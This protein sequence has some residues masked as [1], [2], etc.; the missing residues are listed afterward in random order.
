MKNLKFFSRMAV[1]VAAVSMLMVS[2]KGKEDEVA[3]PADYEGTWVNITAEGMLSA[4]TTA[5]FTKTTFSYT[6]VMGTI[7]MAKLSGTMTVANNKMSQTTTEITMPDLLKVD[8]TKPNVMPT[9][10]YK[11]GDAGWDDAIKEQGGE[12]NEVTY[13]ISGN[14]LTL[15]KD[16]NKDGDFTD[17][18]ETMEFTKQ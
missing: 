5:V 9:V 14:K 17:V 16:E 7:T 4:T 6:S 10:T 18:G 12:V 13:A 2:C 15:K 11:K 8:P 1:V 3:K